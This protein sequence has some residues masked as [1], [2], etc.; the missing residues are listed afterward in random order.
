MAIANALYEL[1]FTAEATVAPYTILKAGA[2]EG[3]AVPASTS[4]DAFLGVSDNA[5]VA[6]G[7]AASAQVKGSALCQYGGAIAYGANVT[8]DANG[9]AVAAGVGDKVLGIAQETGIAGDI[10]PVRLQFQK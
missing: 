1:P 2:T 8:S 9:H 10:R 7:A 6:Q 5:P 3:G 4:T